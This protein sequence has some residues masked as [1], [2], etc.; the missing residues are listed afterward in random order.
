MTPPLN[1]EA[2]RPRVCILCIN[3]HGDKATRLVSVAEV[4]TVRQLRPGFDPAHPSF[5]AGL[6]KHCLFLLSRQ[7]AGK[8]VE[9]L[10]PDEYTVLMPRGSRSQV[11]VPCRCYICHLAKLNGPAFMLWQ[12]E[13]KDRTRPKVTHICSSCCLPVAAE[14]P[15]QPGRRLQGLGGRQGHLQDRVHPEVRVYCG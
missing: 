7:A 1:H 13:V 8:E 15:G 6:C 2:C 12:R 14:D 3:E 5:P 4:A 9:F 11:E 10:L